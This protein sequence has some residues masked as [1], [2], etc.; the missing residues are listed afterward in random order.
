[1]SPAPLI[2]VVGGIASGKSLVSSLL[3]SLGARRFDAD[4]VGH[5]LLD[6][7]TVRGALVG[8]WGDGVLGDG[9]LVSRPAVAERVF[10][11]DAGEDLAFLEQLLHPRIARVLDEELAQ[12]PS[13]TRMV[14]D[15]AL[16]L[17]AG[18]GDR[19]SW[20]VFVD[21]PR[22]DRLRRALERG[23]TE[24]A[25]HAREQQQM[26]LDEKRRRSDHVFANYGSRQ[27]LAIQVKDWWQQLDR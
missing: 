4:Q 8:R 7:P 22:E 2:G 18:W 14:L 1:M 3:E 6:E 13:G 25:F 23:W 24:G 17:E 16:L 10:R 12:T 26:P 9:G 5:R 15:A 21:A 19:C 27:S 11:P 20:I